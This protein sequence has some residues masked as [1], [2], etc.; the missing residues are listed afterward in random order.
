VEK[1]E[2]V[3]V[4]KKK[5]TETVIDHSGQSKEVVE[6]VDSEE[7]EED[8][9]TPLI[10]KR[11]TGV[12]IG[13]EAYME[14]D[15]ENLDHSSKMKG[16]EIL[17]VAAQFKLN[18]KKVRK[19]SK[20]DFILQQRP[21][22]SG[23][24][25]TLAVLDKPRGSS[26]SSSSESN[27]KIKDISSDDERSEADDMEK[28]KKV[29]EDKATKEKL[30]DEQAGEDQVMDEQSEKVQAEDNVPMSQAEKPAEQL[31]RS[32]LTLSSAEYGNQFLNDNHDVSLTNALKEPVEPEVQS[33]VEV[34]KDKLLKL[35][36]KSKS[37]DK[38]PAHRPL[39]DALVQSLLVDED[40]MDKQ[41]KDQSTPKKRRQDDNDQDPFTDL[42]KE[43][44]KIKQKDYESL[45]KDK[46]QAGSSKKGK[47]P[48]KSSKTDKSVNAEKTVHDVEM[49]VEEFV[50]DDVVD[51]EDPTQADASVPTRDKSTWLKKV[52]VERPESLDPE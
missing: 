28:I 17:S 44:K 18:M 25:V 1:I 2:T 4:P 41:L 45:K 52:V 46:D 20:D 49:D 19:A 6:P 8:E 3:R 32:S 23:F 22:G 9:E 14:S 42:Q 37:Y 39:Y 15:E 51:A 24:G 29:K 12:V 5:R 38:H 48:S 27:D 50:E 16:I 10:R 36:M 21:K 43:K 7:T 35:M 33:M 31:L 11:Q 47:S 30:V 40:D 13:R 34:P 26:S